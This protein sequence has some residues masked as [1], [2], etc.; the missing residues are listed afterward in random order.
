M[1]NNVTFCCFLGHTCKDLKKN[2]DETDTDCGGKKCGKCADGKKCKVNPDCI[3][4]S[5][6]DKKCARKY[7]IMYS[8]RFEFNHL[9]SFSKK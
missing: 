9:L 1:Y 8:F 2:Q 4:N 7:R 3:S 5:C 6:K